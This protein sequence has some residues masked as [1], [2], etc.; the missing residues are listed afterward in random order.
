M[1]LTQ[2]DK[3]HIVEQRLKGVPVLTIAR[4]TEH[5]HTTIVKV[6]K[7][8]LRETAQDRADELEAIRE[9]LVHRHEQ[10]AF[11]ARASGEQARQEGNVTA[12]VKYLKEERD[13]LREVAKLTGAEAA[14]KVDV[15]ATVDLAVSDPRELLAEYLLALCP[16]K[17]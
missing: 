15:S 2:G 13:S 6:F 8:W 12:H 9:T 3:D 17:N 7:D 11:V 14:V 10:A 4:T 1:A 16:S 5:S